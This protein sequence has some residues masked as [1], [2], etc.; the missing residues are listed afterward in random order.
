MRK[1]SRYQ[2]L[3]WMVI[4]GCGAPG[5][6]G[7][8]DGLAG[9]SG[10]FAVAIA[11]T[12]ALS[13]VPGGSAQVVAT[14]TPEAG[15][16]G[17]VALS[18]QDLPAGVAMTFEPAQ[19]ALDGAPVAVQLTLRA[20][21]DAAL[22]AAAVSAHVVAAD[23]VGGA[24]ALLGVAVMSADDLDALRGATIAAVE[25][26]LVEL[27]AGP[28]SRTEKL[29]AIAAFM[30]TQPGYLETQLNVAG[31]TATG[32]FTD[33]RLHMVSLDFTPE[34]APVTP[35]VRAAPAPRPAASELAAAPRTAAPTAVANAAGATG[36]EL[37]DS[38]HARVLHAFPLGVVTEPAIQR[39]T[40]YLASRGWLLQSVADPASVERLRG[41]WGDGFF[42]FNTH[43]GW[44]NVA[45]AANEPGGKIY[46]LHVSTPRDPA[47]ERA[48]APP[49]HEPDDSYKTDL[50]LRRLV[51]STV[52]TGRTLLDRNNQWVPEVETH[53]GITHH[54]VTRYWSFAR[55][56]VV[57]IG[58]CNS[59]SDANFVAAI[60]RKNVGAYVGWNGFL[61][62]A[63]IDATL[64]YFVDR[65]IGANQT[66]PETPA[67]RPFRA[68]L[69]M[70]DMAAKG[71][72]TDAVTGAK[73]VALSYAPLPPALAPS[74]RSLVVD[75]FGGQLT[76]RGGF[77]TKAGKVTIDGAE[78]AIRAWAAD[79]IVVDLPLTGPGSSGDVQVEVGGIKSNLRQLSEW[80]MR[81]HYGW[82]P[83]LAAGYG[84]PGTMVQGT[85][86]MRWRGDIAGYRTQPGGPLTFPERGMIATADSAL[87]LTGSGQGGAG[88]CLGIASG[89]GAFP[90][91]PAQTADPVLYSAV[92]VDTQT[93]L[94]AIGLAFGIDTSRFWL[95]FVGDQ[96]PPAMSIQPQFGFLEG[97]NGFPDPTN[98]V[99]PFVYP[100][101]A[102]QVT[103]DSG[104]TLA[105]R[106]YRDRRIGGEIQ[107]QWDATPA[108]APP[109]D[110]PE[111]GK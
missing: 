62:A 32:V 15:Y 46:M 106:D 105:A 61:S 63:G 10:D 76:L 24:E 27:E 44:T 77:G 23:G 70:D 83:P 33:G 47:L 99:D 100:L 29:A 6:T 57:M 71:I 104:S 54:F 20:D 41:V 90:S 30:A 102:L 56:A 64:P 103:F 67:Q 111:S 51:Y 3:A 65:M 35:A 101:P 25:H 94:G 12:T 95:T 1:H 60:V 109:R 45:N 86:V 72:D 38:A 84:V 74:I 22:T 40:D 80:P 17:E 39:A 110:E 16:A 59:A 93:G 42:F 81:L 78:R 89:S 11:A 108:T 68:D 31:L 8:R 53:Y 98:D 26:A 7:A 66:S 69:V 96:C 9:G 21:A 49:A 19:V 2:L 13:V 87:R 34:V 75:E 79:Q 55:N 28:L 82:T 14:I 43:G 73:L 18:A 97:A 107:V 5:L 85:S 36:A 52:P 37:P 91:L 48:V 58:A 4:A 50:D 88:S 92:K